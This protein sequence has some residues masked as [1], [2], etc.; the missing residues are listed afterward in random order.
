[1]ELSSFVTMGK[2]ILYYID[3]V[4]LVVTSEDVGTLAEVV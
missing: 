4:P 1:L 3:V 2:V